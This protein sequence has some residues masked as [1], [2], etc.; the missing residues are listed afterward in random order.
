MRQRAAECPSAHRRIGALALRRVVVLCKVRHLFCLSLG[1]A[2]FYYQSNE[3]I[4]ADMAPALSHVSTA[5][6]PSPPQSKPDGKAWVIVQM[7]LL[8]ALLLISPWMR[9]HWPPVLSFGF[10][11]ALMLYAAITGLAGVFRLGRNRT[12]RP[13]PRAGGEL[14]T[15]GIYGLLRH[16]LYASMMAMGS[17]WALLWSSSAG[18]A[19]AVT[20]IIFLHAK[21]RHEE[22]LLHAAYSGY[23]AYAQQVPRYLPFPR[24]WKKG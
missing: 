1:I 22:K 6:K 24:C 10:G 2:F 17:G 9:G 11:S 12:P 19:L 23:A 14:V 16:P 18:S 3:N 8:T 4:Y 20:F 15:T 5:I 13:Q 21:A 7:L